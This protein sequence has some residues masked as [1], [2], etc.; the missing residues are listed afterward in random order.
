MTSDELTVDTETRSDGLFT[1]PFHRALPRL[2][3][4]PIRVFED[5]GRHAHGRVVRLGLG[6]FRPYLVTEPDHVQYV[7]RENPSNYV[8]EGMI[9]DSVR[10]LQ[11][12]DSLTSEGPGWAASRKLLQPLFSARHVAGLVDM[13]R[14][15]I[16]ETAD[17]LRPGQV[18][19]CSELMSRMVYRALISALFGD[20]ISIEGADRLAT[21]IDTAFTAMRTRMV[22]PFVPESVPLPGDRA[23]RRA[24]ATVDSV[25]YPVVR[26]ARGSTADDHD[27]ISLLVRARDEDGKGLDDRHIRDDIVAMCVGGT[28]TTAVAL[29]WLWVLLERYPRVAERIRAEVAAAASPTDL[30][31]TRMAVSESLRLYP[32]GWNIPRQAVADDVIGGARI[33]AGATVI[34]SAYLT[35]RSPRLWD[36]PDEFEPERFAPGRDKGRHRYAY[37]PFGGG[38][39]QCLGSHFFAV[40]AQLIVAALLTRFRPHVEAADT[41]RPKVAVTLRPTGPVPLTL[42][43]LAG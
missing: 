13:M 10:R 17:E 2:V 20:R 12:F 32:T 5:I 26:A 6:P 39:H 36:R 28:E 25:I 14:A 3:R 19:E 8:R 34:V 15:A 33:P 22:M 11:G 7:L 37:F 1:L 43:P 27:V 40:E 24:V 29:T 42:R 30:R 31:Y 35:H 9:W 38:P 16:D 4:D 21:A 18:V 41:V 23:F